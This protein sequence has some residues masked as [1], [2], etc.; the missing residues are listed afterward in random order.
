[1]NIKLENYLSKNKVTI[2]SRTYCDSC[3]KAKEIIRNHGLSLQIHEV[4]LNEVTSEILNDLYKK[5]KYKRF[6]NIFIGRESIKGLK[7]LE[8]LI[9]SGEFQ[10]LI[11]RHQ[12]ERVN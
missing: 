10:A 4:D 9:E 12:I 8:S 11:N 3:Q 5:S 1:M 2:F 7:Q 6:P